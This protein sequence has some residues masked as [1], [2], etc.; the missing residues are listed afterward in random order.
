VS[1]DH[2]V[3]VHGD[4][5]VVQLTP[6]DVV[7]VLQQIIRVIGEPFASEYYM[8]RGGKICVSDLDPGWTR[9]QLGLRIW[10]TNPDPDPGRSKLAPKKGNN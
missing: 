5:L 7:S 4:V 10:S 8:N 1:P 2:S 9:I 6:H 3:K